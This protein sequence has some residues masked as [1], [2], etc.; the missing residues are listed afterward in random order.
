MSVEQNKA[1]L[2]HYIEEVWNQENPAA[3]DKFLAPTYRRHRSPAQPPLTP[4]EQKQ[5]LAGF[6]AT[7]PDIKITVEDMIAEGGQNCLSLHNAGYSSGRI[8]GN[9][10]YRPRGDIFSAR[11][12][13]Y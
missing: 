1:L 7:F 10:A 8:P 4:E 13:S 6:R 3:V 9:F 2:H 12:D 5:L 11:R